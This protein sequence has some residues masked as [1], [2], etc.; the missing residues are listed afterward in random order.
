MFAAALAMAM[1]CPK[2]RRLDLEPHTAAK[3]TTSN[4]FFHEADSTIAYPTFIVAGVSS[5]HITPEQMP[6][7]MKKSLPLFE[8]ARLLL[9]LEHVARLIVNANHRIV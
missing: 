4:N 7:A 3:T 6:D 5:P 9:R 2:K 8:I 1:T